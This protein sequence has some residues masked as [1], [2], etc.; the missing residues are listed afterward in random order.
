MFLFTIVF[1]FEILVQLD[2]LQPSQIFLQMA[3]FY[4][5]TNLRRIMEIFFVEWLRAVYW[6]L[7]WVFLSIHDRIILMKTFIFFSWVILS[8]KFLN[9]SETEVNLLLW[10]IYAGMNIFKKFLAIDFKK[11][12][13]FIP[14]LSFILILNDY[15]SFCR[16]L[17]FQPSTWSIWP[18]RSF[19]NSYLII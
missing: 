5:G 11:S 10:E 4:T 9:F 15:F 12:Q 1:V 19:L 18:L 17:A 13:M 3:Q 16:F 6:F 7:W 14:S 2:F 8:K